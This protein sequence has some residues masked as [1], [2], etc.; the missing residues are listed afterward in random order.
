[1]ATLAINLDYRGDIIA[2]AN[3]LIG[4]YEN[5]KGD[6]HGIIGNINGVKTSRSNLSSCTYYL[7]RKNQQIDGK[8]GMAR[9]LCSRIDTVVDHAKAADKRVADHI[10]DSSEQFYKAMGIK[11][12]LAAAWDAVVKGAKKI[13]EMVIEFYEKHKYLIDLVVN[14]VLL[15]AA[16]VAFV[17]ALALGPVAIFFAAFA[18]IGAVCDAF[19]S[20]AAFGCWAGGD[21]EKAAKWADRNL[22]KEGFTTVLGEDVGS[23][24][25]YGLEL[26]SVVYSVRGAAKNVKNSFK[27]SRHGDKLKNAFKQVRREIFGIQK[28]KEGRGVLNTLKG[29][30]GIRT[31]KI[32]QRI[33]TGATF[34]LNIK[35]IYDT[36]TFLS[37][38]INSSAKIG[39]GI[40]RTTIR[41]SLR[42]IT[43]STRAFCLNGW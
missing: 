27:Y 12:G 5:R 40:V 16:V 4:K 13:G 37:G 31:Q 11:T 26:A 21:E 36:P 29:V 33:L 19:S 32:A 1:M 8:I 25:Y 3:S 42:P 39:T 41:D 14:I 28:G 10:K 7:R 9:N 17:G 6:Y 22:L 35:T 30:F 20:S 34:A 2:H 43:R 18:L 24:A 38:A 15:A 23:F